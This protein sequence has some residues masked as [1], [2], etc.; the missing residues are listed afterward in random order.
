MNSARGCSRFH[1][2]RAKRI[3]R[4]A[5]AFSKACGSASPLAHHRITWPLAV[6]SRNARFATPDRQRAAGIAGRLDKFT[7]VG[8]QLADGGDASRRT[9]PARALLASSRLALFCPAR[10]MGGPDSE[11]GQPGIHSGPNGKSKLI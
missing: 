6:A 10:P 4:H 7:V 2:V 1:F 8:H 3:G 5:G 11:G 9:P